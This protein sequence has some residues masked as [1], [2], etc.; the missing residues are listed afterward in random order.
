MKKTLAFTC[1][2]ALVATACSDTGVGPESHGSD[3]A[4]ALGGWG[5]IASSTDYKLNV[6]GVRKDKTAAMDDNSGRRIFVRLKGGAPVC[7]TDEDWALYL[8]LLGDAAGDKPTENPF[9]C[10]ER[11]WADANRL[12]GGRGKQTGGWDNL[13]KINKILLTPNSISGVD[14]F[15]VLDANATDGDGAELTMPDDVATYYEVY[16]RALGKPGGKAAMTLCANEVLDGA[17]RTVDDTDG[18][19]GIDAT[20]TETWCS[21]NQA[22]LVR[23]KGPPKAVDV[24]D[25]LFTLTVLVDP[26]Q[27]K[28]VT[29]GACLIETNVIGMG[30]GDPLTD[31]TQIADVPIFHQCFEDYFWNYDNDGLKLL[32]LWFVRKPVPTA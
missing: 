19:G 16:A 11:E 22:I 24:T 21:I 14:G 2:L 25:E 4:A 12:N 23:E 32:Q 7:V 29:L 10:T 15:R 31:D 27:T 6:I 3:P 20:D 8:E 5:G 9:S 17:G 26:D 13:D 18:S 30:D 28:D 1:S